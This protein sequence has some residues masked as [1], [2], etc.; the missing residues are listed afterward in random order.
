MDVVFNHV[1]ESPLQ[2]L[3]KD[4][5]VDGNTAWGDEINYDNPAC[6]RFL[7]QA[8]VYLWRTFQVDGFRFDSTI[9]IIK[10]NQQMDGVINTPGSGGGWELLNYLRAA[11]RRAADAEGRG[12]PYFVGEN[13]P[14]DWTITN[15]SNGGVLDGQ[16]DFAFNYPVGD[17]AWEGGDDSSGIASGMALPHIWLRPFSE[18]VRYGESH[19]SCGNRGPGRLRIARRAP[20]GRGFQ[21]AKAVGTVALLAHGVPMLFM[22][23]EGGED[24]DF[25]FDFD[26]ATNRGDLQYF[27]RL[28]YYDDLGDQRN[29]IVAWYRDLIGLRMNGGNGLRG[30]DTQGLGTGYRTVAFSRAGGRFFV[31]ATLGTTDTRQNLGWLQ[32]PDG[33]SSYKEIFNSSWPAYSVE[34][35]QNFSNGSYDAVLTSSSIVNLPP[36]GG[37]VLERR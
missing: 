28:P 37:I 13:D 20:F 19:D 25:F 35:E 36:V 26:M 1:V 14:N 4:V 29:R 24:Q 22:G 23:Q 8:M 15:N 16:W 17:G 6:M 21:T 12:W 10:G 32:L 11:V 9:A 7:R 5:Y 34:N 18:A 27:A 30:N 2:A 33:G 3:A 31:I